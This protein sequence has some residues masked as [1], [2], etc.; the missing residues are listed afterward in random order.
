MGRSLAVVLAVMGPG[1]ALAHPG[2]LSDV[3]GHDH[4]V[5]GAAIGTAVV[6]GLWA[7]PARPQRQAR[8]S[9]RKF[10]DRAK[11]RIRSGLTRK[12]GRRG[13]SRRCRKIRFRW[14]GAM[15]K[16]RARQALPRFFAVPVCLSRGPC[17]RVRRR[18]AAA[19]WP[20][21]GTAPAIA[22]TAC[23]KRIRGPVPCPCRCRAHWRLPDTSG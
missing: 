23:R 18:L 10:C 7:G 6:L 1:V 11:S 2:H 14:S 21:S 19:G 16:S 17:G 12:A 5:A 8:G 3:A 22:R 4:W 9:L 20:R 15:V 13:V